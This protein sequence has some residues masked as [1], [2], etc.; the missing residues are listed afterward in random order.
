MIQFYTDFDQ[1]YF[2]YKEILFKHLYRYFGFKLIYKITNTKTQ[3]SPFLIKKIQLT[4]HFLIIVLAHKPNIIGLVF[5]A[6]LYFCP[7]SAEFSHSPWLNHTQC[8][9]VSLVCLYQQHTILSSND[10]EA[11]ADLKP[12]KKKVAVY[13]IRMASAIFVSQLWRREKERQIKH[14]WMTNGVSMALLV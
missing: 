13:C 14:M 12:L 9:N 7:N 10:G 5:S 8:Y 1:L 3:I 2:L 11:I 6:F 4:F